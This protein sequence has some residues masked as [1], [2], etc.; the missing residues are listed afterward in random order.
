MKKKPSSDCSS[1]LLASQPLGVH[2]PEGEGG[3]AKTEASVSN[4]DGGIPMSVAA[5]GDS[6]ASVQPFDVNFSTDSSLVLLA[7]QAL[8]LE[9][10][11]SVSHQLLTASAAECKPLGQHWSAAVDITS[12]ALPPSASPVGFPLADSCQVVLPELLEVAGFARHVDAGQAQVIR[13]E[14]N[15]TIQWSLSCRFTLGKLE[16]FLWLSLRFVQVAWL[17]FVWMSFHSVV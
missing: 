15:I 2:L 7:D 16:L 14:A 13:A 4:V 10:P 12:V 11:L 17:N 6:R 8:A 9:Q 3:V 1:V 5:D